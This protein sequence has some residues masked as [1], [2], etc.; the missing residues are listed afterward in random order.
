MSDE[1]PAQGDFRLD[2]GSRQVHPGL[3]EPLAP[4]PQRQVPAMVGESVRDSPDAD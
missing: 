3:P 2:S 4:I 1:A